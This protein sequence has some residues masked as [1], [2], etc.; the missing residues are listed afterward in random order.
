MPIIESLFTPQVMLLLMTNYI[1]TGL[2][3]IDEFGNADLTMILNIL[4]NNVLG[5]LKIIVR[6]V[7]DLI[8]EL[9]MEFFYE[10]VLPL[11]VK[12]KLAIELEKVNRW[13][14]VLAIA[15]ACIPRLDFL[16]KKK[17][18]STIDEVNYADITNV[19]NIPENNS[20]C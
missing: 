6:F 18:I 11:L 20:G 8:I 17:I 2:I 14:E 13:L 1:M 19:Q 10:K 12:Y 9:L 16:K 5:L 7:I 3:K 15:L 4:L